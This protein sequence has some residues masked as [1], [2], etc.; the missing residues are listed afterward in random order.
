MS[1][2]LQF[3]NGAYNVSE[4]ECLVQCNTSSCETLT[5]GKQYVAKLDGKGKFRVKNNLG[6]WSPYSSKNFT[7]VSSSIH[8]TVH[9]VKV[10]SSTTSSETETETETSV[11]TEKKEEFM[12]KR[13]ITAR[14]FLLNEGVPVKT[15]DAMV[16]Y[17]NSAPIVDEELKARIPKINGNR[18]FRGGSVLRQVITNLLAGKNVILEGEKATGKNVLAENMAFYFQR[19]VWNISCHSYTDAGS[20]IGNDTLRDGNIVFKPAGIIEAAKHGGF[21]VID[22][23][24]MAKADATS[25]LHSLFDDRRYIDIPG[26]D[27]VYA[28]ECTRFIGTMNYGYTGTRELSEAYTSR[29]AIIHIEPLNIDDLT[30]LLHMSFPFYSTDTLKL[31]ATVFDDLR[32]KARHGEI[33]TKSVDFRG[34]K[35]AVDLCTYDLPPFEALQCCIINKAFEQYERTIIEDTIKT[36]VPKETKKIT[37]LISL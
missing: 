20:L 35:S 7:M 15:I 6:K 24:N 12:S 36:I 28:H 32:E 5:L 19:P 3:V 9:S 23:L 13:K 33:S 26:Y 34:I 18:L 8:G 22:E 1:I 16:A 37:D 2:V 27:R 11:K 31:F 4:K 30:A 17:R 25:V 29:F 10:T 21:C 14:D